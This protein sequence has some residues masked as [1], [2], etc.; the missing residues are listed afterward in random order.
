ML[1]SSIHSQLCHLSSSSQN[2]FSY[3]SDITVGRKV[4]LFPKNIR[5]TLGFLVPLI[6]KESFSFLWAEPRR[7]VRVSGFLSCFPESWL[8]YSPGFLL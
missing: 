1:W 5:E 8:I 6:N 3:C 4:T 2:T 7:S